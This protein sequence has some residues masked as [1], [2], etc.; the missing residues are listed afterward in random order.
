VLALG[1]SRGAA[2]STLRADSA[3]FATATV[4]RPR[5]G[6]NLL[7]PTGRGTRGMVMVARRPNYNAHGYS[8]VIFYA[9][10]KNDASDREVWQL[11]PFDV[12]R[13]EDVRT[14][15]GADCAVRDVRVLRLRRSGPLQVVVGERTVLRSY[16]DA[17]RVTFTVYGLRENQDQA[18][19]E[20]LYRFERLRQIH[21]TRPY[22]DIN[23]AFARE[24]GLGATG[25]ATPG[26]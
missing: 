25:I 9:M 22:C 18:A 24:L 1:V 3:R 12:P 21:P 8:L 16:T 26:D 15:E 20:P 7:D 2:Q 6:M 4:F 19:G 23:E 17:E 13:D 5:N 11:I 14:H 10:G